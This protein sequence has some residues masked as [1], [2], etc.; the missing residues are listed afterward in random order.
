MFG[1]TVSGR[2]ITDYREVFNVKTLI[3]IFKEA[4]N[5]LLAPIGNL[6]FKDIVISNKSLTDNNSGFFSLI[7]LKSNRL[8]VSTLNISVNHNQN[9]IMPALS[10]R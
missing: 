8:K 9:S 2:I 5:E 4:V 6:D 10:F 7:A 1:L 3:E